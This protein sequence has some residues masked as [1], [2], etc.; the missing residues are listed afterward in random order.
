MVIT[1]DSDSSNPGSIPGTTF[2]HPWLH[3]PSHLFKPT[4]IWLLLFLAK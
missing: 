4:I 3:G 1:L 2:L